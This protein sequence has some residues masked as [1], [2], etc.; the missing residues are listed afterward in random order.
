[1]HQPLRLFAASQRASSLH[2][3]WALLALEKVR[4]PFN[5]N[6]IAQ[7]GALAA[8]DDTAHLE[9]TRANNRRGLDLLQSEFARLGLE[10]VESHANFVLVEVGDGARVFAELQ[11]RG[12]ITRPMGSYRLPGWIRISVGTPAENDRCLAALREVLGR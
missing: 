6:S 7:A 12:V 5:I 1:M 11:K 3:L 9:G 8:L 2:C 10:F 4:Q